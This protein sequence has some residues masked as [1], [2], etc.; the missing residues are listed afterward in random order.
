MYHVRDTVTVKKFM[1]IMSVMTTVYRDVMK[2][3]M[4]KKC[5]DIY[6]TVQM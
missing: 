3:T 1:I 6:Y 5:K 4:A 2:A